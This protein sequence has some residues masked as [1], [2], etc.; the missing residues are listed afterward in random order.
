M[1][2][3]AAVPP[4]LRSPA[5]QDD[6]RGGA[7]TIAAHCAD[8]RTNLGLFSLPLVPAQ[9]RTVRHAR[10]DTLAGRAY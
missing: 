10:R 8:R 5:Q 3:I 7:Q 9:G 4:L 6:H 1:S 2:P